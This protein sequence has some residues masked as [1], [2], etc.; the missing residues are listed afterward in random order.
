MNILKLNPLELT[1]KIQNREIQLTVVGLGKMGL[2]IA[3]VFTNAGFKVKGLDISE[4]IISELNQG[5]TTIAEPEVLER[6]GKAV[7]NGMFKAYID[8]KE[9]LDGSNFVLIIIPVLVDD[10]GNAELDG[11]L[12]TYDSLVK[13]APPGIVFIQETTLPPTTTSKVIVPRIEKQGKKLDDDFGIVFAPERTYSGRA[14]RDIEQNYP[15]IIG[16]Q[17]QKSGVA[18]KLL[19]E[20]VSKK[21]VILV[22]DPTT[23]EAIKTFKGAYRDANIAIAN[24][25][26]VL[27]DKIDIDILEVI[28]VANTEPFSHIHRPGIG[29]GGHCIPVYPHFVIKE[30]LNHGFEPMLFSDGR[31]ANDY[32]VNYAIERI[33]EVT[34]NWKRNVLIMGL[35]YRGGVKEHRLSPTLRIIPKVKELKPLSVKIIDPLYTMKEIENIFGSNTAFEPNELEQALDW[36]SIIIIVTDHKEFGEVDYRLFS[37]KIIYDGRYVIDPALTRDFF[38]IQPGRIG[39]LKSL[40]IL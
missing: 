39:K 38:L 28:D 27:A 9:A 6:L 29:V 30:G 31:K 3:M 37:N 2:P 19:Y 14:I 40:K 16:P 12:K 23:A 35:A 17:T 21:G 20:I 22:S 13:N 33:T 7:K 8:P 34:P 10:Q 26:A 15:K 5:N 11:L 24:Q 18:A 32:M 4:K 1:E 25:L 36:A